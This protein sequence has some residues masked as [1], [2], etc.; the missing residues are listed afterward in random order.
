MLMSSSTRRRASRSAACSSPA[1]LLCSRTASCAWR[2][3]TPALSYAALSAARRSAGS[4]ELASRR[5][6]RR[7]SISAS[8]LAQAAS[9]SSRF[10]HSASTLLSSLDSSASI[11]SLRSFA[12]SS[13]S[14]IFKRFWSASLAVAFHFLTFASIAVFAASSGAF[15]AI[16]AWCCCLNSL[17][18]SFFSACDAFSL[19]ASLSRN[20]ASAHSFLPR[21][22]SRRR[23]FSCSRRKR[24]TSCS[25]ALLM[26]SRS[27]R[28]LLSV[29]SRCSTVTTSL[30]SSISSWCWR[31]TS[32][33]MAISVCL[34]S[35]TGD[36][37]ENCPTLS[38]GRN[39][40][41]LST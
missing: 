5:A 37:F 16:F 38:C 31:Y 34:S 10:L 40:S 35:S 24:S 19:A 29:V 17:S 3:S 8:S 26:R 30:S 6:C 12:A 25:S 9:A 20:S 32:G 27:P 14:V 28:L 33:P 36:M 7:C 18:S 13:S 22:P 39:W 21:K 11:F 41:G 4:S 1:W 15:C 23:L 2:A